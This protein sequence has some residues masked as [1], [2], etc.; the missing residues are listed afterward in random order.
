MKKYIAPH[1]EAIFF[2][3]E[4][5]LLAGTLDDNGGGSGGVT[6]D[7]NG[8]NGSFLMEKRGWNSEDWSDEES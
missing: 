3:S 4:S 7:N 6:P 8:H 2:Q 1:A 5:C